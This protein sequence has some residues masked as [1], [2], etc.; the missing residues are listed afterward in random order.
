MSSTMRTRCPPS[1]VRRSS[2]R[3][4]LITFISTAAGF[5]IGWVSHAI[6]GRSNLIDSS[7]PK[8]TAN[9]RGKRQDGGKFHAKNNCIDEII[10]RRPNWSMGYDLRDWIPRW[11]PEDAVKVWASSRHNETHLRILYGGPEL[12]LPTTDE[13]AAS[14]DAYFWNYISRSGGSWADPSS[15]F[16]VGMSI[17]GIGHRLQHLTYSYMCNGVQNK[18]QLLVDWYVAE[19]S[20]DNRMWHALF[21]DS[22][23][24]VG[25][26]P[27]WSQ[28]KEEVFQ[29]ANEYRS[30]SGILGNLFA[31]GINKGG[32]EEA[33]DFN[34]YFMVESAG[35]MCKHW[36]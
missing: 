25:L 33:G 30:K 36:S 23:V 16:S 12:S 20:G 11:L 29:K 15:P 2:S 27:H 31:D 19:F 28:N 35:G 17:T 34:Q 1:A 24:L 8:L 13:E 5:A 18:R 21:E 26:P 6:S 4:I 32:D 10:S 22:P 3:I 7:L 9:T 14:R